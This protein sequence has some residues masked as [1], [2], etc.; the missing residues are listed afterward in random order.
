MRSATELTFRLHQE[1]ADLRMFVAPP[2]LPDHALQVSS[3]LAPLPDPGPTVEALLDSAY[4]QDVERIAKSLLA[5]RFPLLG[6]EIATGSA[7]DWTRDYVSGRTTPSRYFRFVPFLEFQRVGDHKVIWEL[8]RHQHLVT[9]A[10]AGRLTGRDEFFEEIARQLDGWIEANPF[11]RGINWTSALEVALRAL[12]WLW[13][14]HLGAHRLEASLRR[15][16][17][18]TLY[19]HGCYLAHNLSVHFSPNTHLL[20]EAVALYALGTLCPQF[21]GAAGWKGLG[22]RI[23]AEALRLQ[24]RD[25]G[26]HFEQ[27]TYYHVYALDFFLFHYLLGGA[28]P[29]ERLIRMAE[30]LAAV[31]GPQRLVPFLGDDDGGRVF[32]PF[33]P[34]HRFGCAT[35]A[36]CGIAFDRPDWI[37][38]ESELHELAY[39]WI[40]PRPAP[41]PVPANPAQSS[42]WFPEAGIAVW[43]CG[44]THVVID[45]G[46]FGR[47]SGGHSHSDT[48]SLMVRLGEDDI[49][50][51]PGTF[52]YVADPALRNWF[53][54]SAAHNTISVDASDQAVPAGPFAWREPPEVAVRERRSAGREEILDAECR[55]RGLT[56]RRRIVWT[57]PRRIVIDDEVSGPPGEHLVEQFWHFGTDPVQ[58]GPSSFRIGSRVILNLTQEAE[59]ELT[60]RWRSSAFGAKSAAAV[61][62]VFRRCALPRS[63]RSVLELSTS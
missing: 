58:L 24:V 23:A 15:R 52:T 12:S 46:P 1:L 41:T 20:G 61:L 9:L 55:Y 34:R 49:L 13:V 47:G 8:N 5:H 60:G 56:H 40:G 39:W 38:Q 59:H 11:L 53:R 19:R 22:G 31:M 4:A 54:G 29:R 18:N 21:P 37:S 45:A 33:G 44:D 17:L 25:D 35:L 62:R 36:A 7:I 50:I 10:Q 28:L 6:L 26:S 32:H 48:L 16:F 14:L 63:W 51:D 43:T 27:S 30:F 2:S 57:K 3:P 42:F